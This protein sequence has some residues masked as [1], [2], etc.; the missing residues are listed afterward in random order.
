MFVA[1]F[2]AFAV[3]AWYFVDAGAQ[4][5]YVG[6]VAGL[7]ATHFGKRVLE[8][9]FSVCN[10][11]ISALQLAEVHLQTLF[12]H[13]YSGGMSFL[14][15]IGIS[16]LYTVATASICR[17]A[18][19]VP[20]KEAAHH[21]SRWSLLGYALFGIGILGNLYHHVLLRNLRS[22]SG[23]EK[24]YKAPESGLFKYVVCP[25][26]FLELVQF[27]GMAIVS[28]QTVHYAYVLSTLG[29]FVE[30]SNATLKWYREKLPEFDKQKAVKRLIPFLY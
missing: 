14:T 21:L 18:T 12:L 23:A 29:Y 4:A 28:G 6:V 22:S 26:Y 27:L 5:S 19:T 11:H 1:Y 10:F 30:R 3:G 7:F 15:M 24:Q 16:T 2:P 17:V 25:H 8:V 20:I 9:L 13:R